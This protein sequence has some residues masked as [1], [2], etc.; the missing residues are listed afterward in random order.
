MGSFD[1]YFSCHFVAALG[2]LLRYVYEEPYF[3]YGKDYSGL[4]SSKVSFCILFWTY[5]VR[6]ILTSLNMLFNTSLKDGESQD[7]F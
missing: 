2:F 5:G 7:I 1:R 4:W 6:A 3:V